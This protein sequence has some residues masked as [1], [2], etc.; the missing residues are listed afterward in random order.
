MHFSFSGVAR[1]ESKVSITISIFTRDGRGMFFYR[2]GRGEAKNLVGR[3]VQGYTFAG[4]GTFCAYA[5]WNTCHE[6]Y[7]TAEKP[8]IWIASSKISQIYFALRSWLYMRGRPV[9]HGAGHTSLIFTYLF[10][11][12]RVEK[13]I[14]FSLPLIGWT[15]WS[16]A[17]RGKGQH[18]ITFLSSWKNIAKGTTDPGVD[19][20]N[21]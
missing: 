3:A 18:W 9:F 10:L 5:E 11:V 20:F 13:L 15:D 12:K 1:G 2:A 7:V 19:Y 6:S 4:Q 21:Q 16:I 14:C 8:L 17:M